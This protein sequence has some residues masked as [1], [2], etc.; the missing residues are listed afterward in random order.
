MQYCFVSEGSCT[1]PGQARRDK[2]WERLIRDN[3]II[4]LVRAGV[5]I[6]HTHPP[7]CPPPHPIEVHAN[8][9]WF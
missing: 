2:A 9:N 8:K 7:L 4:R 5:P 1:P 3:Y 6:D